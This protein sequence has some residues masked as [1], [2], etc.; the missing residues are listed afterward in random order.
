M[1][2]FISLQNYIV[3]QEKDFGVGVPVTLDEEIAMYESTRKKNVA[4]FNN[5]ML[6]NIPS[7]SFFLDVNK[8]VSEQSDDILNILMNKEFLMSLFI[9]VAK[10]TLNEIGNYI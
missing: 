3:K 4:S 5:W 8:P 6:I 10:K 2:A 1:N 7:K 9:L